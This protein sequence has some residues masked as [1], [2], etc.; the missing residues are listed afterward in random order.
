MSARYPPTSAARMERALY[1]PSTL[2]L[3]VAVSKIAGM[4]VSNI[5]NPTN[6]QTLCCRS[7]FMNGLTSVPPLEINIRVNTE[8]SIEKMTKAIASVTT[9]ESKRSSR[10]SRRSALRRPSMRLGATAHLCNVLNEYARRS[11]PVLRSVITF[12][13]IKILHCPVTVT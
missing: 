6:A 10:A 13:A 2:R 7:A 4:Q 8:S 1:R 5:L 11:V 12:M 9:P 3:P